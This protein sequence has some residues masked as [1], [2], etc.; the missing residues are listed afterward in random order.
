M[1][2]SVFTDI[3]V[4]GFYGYIGGKLDKKYQWNEYWWKLIEMLRKTS[5]NDEMRNNIHIRVVY[6]YIY[7]YIIFFDIL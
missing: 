5:R 2:I 1:K 7:I 6:I 3:S 4:V